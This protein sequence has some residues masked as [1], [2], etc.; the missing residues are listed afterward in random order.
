MN[1]L[2]KDNLALF[3]E[4]KSLSDQL[5]VHLAKMYPDLAPSE[6]QLQKQKRYLAMLDTLQDEQASILVMNSRVR[7]FEG[8]ASP[9]KHERGR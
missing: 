5:D 2:R 7:K 3:R 6:E 1:S 9:T 4:L 8:G